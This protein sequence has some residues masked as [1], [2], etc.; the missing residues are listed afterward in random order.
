MTLTWGNNKWKI[1]PNKQYVILVK[2]FPVSI[3]GRFE[4]MAIGGRYKENKWIEC[5]S[6]HILEEVYCIGS[7]PMV[8]RALLNYQLYKQGEVYTNK[9]HLN[10]HFYHNI[11][12]YA[13]IVNEAYAHYMNSLQ[14]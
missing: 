6:D 8:R 9:P 3:S 10:E 14:Q 13:K 4:D 11:H 2:S 1:Y 7:V 12:K 5:K